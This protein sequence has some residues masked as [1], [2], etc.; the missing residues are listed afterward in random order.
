MSCSGATLPVTSTV[1][2][3]KFILALLTPGTVL[4][5]CSILATQLAQPA[6]SM[7]SDVSRSAIR[8]C[9]CGSGRELVCADVWDVAIALVYTRPQCSRHKKGQTLS[10]LVC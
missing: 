1:R 10:A 9:D 8:V 3:A 2:C 6:P 5:D 7:I 4:R